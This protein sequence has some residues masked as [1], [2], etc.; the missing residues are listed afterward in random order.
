[1]SEVEKSARTPIE[2]GTGSN[3][4]SNEP[5]EFQAMVTEAINGTIKT[6]ASE[7]IA[8][9]EIALNDVVFHMEIMQPRRV[10]PPKK[11]NPGFNQDPTPTPLDGRSHSA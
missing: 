8:P 2:T 6:V 5:R 1:V 4:V 3:G 10:S 9:R 7:P 11:N